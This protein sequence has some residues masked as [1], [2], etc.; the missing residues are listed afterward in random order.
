MFYVL[1]MLFRIYGG[2]LV[3]VTEGDCGHGRSNLMLAY[4]AP[5]ILIYVRMLIALFDSFYL[6]L[7]ALLILS[8]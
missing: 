4:D 7:A 6:R 5:C 3:G 1:C 8:A 2:R